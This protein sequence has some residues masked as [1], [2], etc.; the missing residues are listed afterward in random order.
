MEPEQPSDEGGPI[1]LD[2]E[3]LLR[4]SRALLQQLDRVL[5]PDMIDLRDADDSTPDE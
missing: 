4:Q 2:H 5:H 1:L 3:D